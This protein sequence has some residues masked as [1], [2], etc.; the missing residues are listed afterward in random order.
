[1][2]IIAG[3][4]LY[5]REAGFTAAPSALR[6]DSKTEMAVQYRERLDS[7]HISSIGKHLSINGK[8]AGENWARVTSSDAEKRL[9]LV[10]KHISKAGELLEEMEEIAE[11]ATD[12]TL[13][14][15]DRWELQARMGYLQHELDTETDIMLMLAAGPDSLTE[16]EARMR[17]RDMRGE[18]Y[19]SDAYK[20]LDRA[21][22]RISG[23][24]EWDV[25]ETAVLVD[26]YDVEYDVTNSENVPSVGEILKGKGRSVMDANAAAESKAE[27]EK[28]IDGLANLRDS[29]VSL[30]NIYGETSE[31]TGAGDAIAQL[32]GR[33]V[34]FLQSLSKEMISPLAAAEDKEGAAAEGQAPADISFSMESLYA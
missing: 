30:V 8:K 9:Q 4:Q 11:A 25:R 34:K 28:N 29:L 18:Y 32:Y 16:E 21:R 22:E 17:A 19:D 12:E 15:R 13:D 5:L 14:I 33:T 20:M 7:V 23:G 6:A 24:L 2:T 31:E 10:D 26:E 3:S 1:M 27:L